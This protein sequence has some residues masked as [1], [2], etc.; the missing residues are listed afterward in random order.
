[1]K[2]IDDEGHECR[3]DFEW[4]PYKQ[5]DARLAKAVLPEWRRKQLERTAAEKQKAPQPVK[6]RG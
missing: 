4:F 6:A 1:M 2:F 5:V 3:E